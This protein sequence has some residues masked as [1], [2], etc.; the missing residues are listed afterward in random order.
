MATYRDYQ[1]SI[2]DDFFT[3]EETFKQI[4]P[5]I[6]KDKKVYMPFYSPYS[7]CNEYLGKYIDN[8]IVYEDKD[9]FSYKITDGI[10][11]D[12]PPFSIK[13]KIL[14]K[15]FEDDTPFMLILPISS[16]C[17]KYFRLYQNTDLQIIIF[18][19]R[20]KYNKCNSD[21][22]IYDGKSSPAFDSVVFC[23]KIG[24]EKDIIFA[25]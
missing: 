21:G 15:L 4:A 10:I 3:K 25:N 20:P 16:I 1:P 11:C 14:K 8:E 24:L 18:N 7:K 23:Y 12:N 9:F 6:P 2:H 17:Y 5:F 19:G 13:Q 22:V